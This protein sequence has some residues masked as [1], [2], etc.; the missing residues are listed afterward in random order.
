MALKQAMTPEFQLYQRQVVANCRVL[1]ETLMEL[2]YKVVTGT[3]RIPGEAPLLLGVAFKPHPRGP[4]VPQAPCYNAGLTRQVWVGV[5]LPPGPQVM[6]AWEPHLALGG[7][8]PDSLAT[9]RTWQSRQP[10]TARGLTGVPG[11]ESPPP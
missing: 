6:R 11:E 9:D 5:R 1:A 7:V 2:G 3:K 4:P 8:G 10:G